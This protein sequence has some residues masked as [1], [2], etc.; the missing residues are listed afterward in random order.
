[1][2]LGNVSFVQGFRHPSK[3]RINRIKECFVRIRIQVFK[4]VTKDMNVIQLSFPWI[5]SSA[6]IRGLNHDNVGWIP[7]A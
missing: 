4:L 6:L 5:L 1:M 7:W 3:R 2:C